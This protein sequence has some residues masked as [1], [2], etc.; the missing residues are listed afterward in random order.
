MA[1][2]YDSDGNKVE[3]FT[4][5]ELA[6]KLEEQRVAEAAKNADKDKNFEE[7]RKQKEEAEQKLTAKEQADKT[8][9]TNQAVD[10]L[11]QNNK[12]L[13]D[14]I[15]HH[16]KRFE[17]EIK[18]PEDFQRVLNDA[19]VLSAGQQVPDALQDVVS[20]GGSKG[21]KGGGGSGKLPISQDAMNVAGK[22]GLTEDEIKEANK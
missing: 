10:A 22:M 7:L 6:A 1:E 17:A 15:H 5:E 18:T 20:S 12:E 4:P 9:E 3:G 21:G 14:K 16:L 8:K 11:A 2:L 19:Y 13:A